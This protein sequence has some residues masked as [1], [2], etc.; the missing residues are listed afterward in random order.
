M[1]FTSPDSAAR[2]RS[3]GVSRA[4]AA[5]T[6]RPTNTARRQMRWRTR[7]SIKSDLLRRD[8]QSGALTERG[9]QNDARELRAA[10]Q[11]GAV[12]EAH[13]PAHVEL[14]LVLHL[15]QTLLEPAVQQRQDGRPEQRDADLPAVRVPAEHELGAPVLQPR[16]AVGVVRERHDRLGGVDALERGLRRE[17]GRVEVFQADEPEPVRALAATALHRDRLVAQHDAPALDQRRLQRVR[18]ERPRLRAR[19]AGG[20]VVVAEADEDGDAN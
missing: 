4:A 6:N 15:E 10:A 14:A 1:A 17:T 13:A 8:T 9:A 11:T 5:L 12:Q 19:G 16:G 18:E 7:T 20:V 2:S 3:E